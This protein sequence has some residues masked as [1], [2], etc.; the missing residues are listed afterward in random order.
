MDV[1]LSLVALDVCQI[2]IR[3]EQGIKE[4]CKLFQIADF[5]MLNYVRSI[6]VLW[7][8]S[9]P[10]PPVYIQL[11]FCFCLQMIIGDTG[12]LM[13]LAVSHGVVAFATGPELV[14]KM[15]LLIRDLPSLEFP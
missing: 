14:T 4:L 3:Y 11:W 10:L 7:L 5:S 2:V 6:L 8:L 1:I 9:Q 12:F 15:I 13:V